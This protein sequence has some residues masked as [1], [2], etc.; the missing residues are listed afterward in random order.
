MMARVPRLV[1]SH[2]WAH[3][4]A[5]EMD[6]R[7][8]E[9]LVPHSCSL[10]HPLGMALQVQRWNL[11]LTGV[12]LAAASQ[13]GDGTALCPSGS[14]VSTLGLA[15]VCHWV[16]HVCSELPGLCVSSQNHQPGFSVPGY[17]ETHL[18]TRLSAQLF[19][20]WLLHPKTPATLPMHAQGA[21]P[22][23]RRPRVRPCPSRR[24]AARPCRCSSAA[25]GRTL[26]P[27]VRPLFVSFS[28]RV[29]LYPVP[30]APPRPRPPAQPPPEPAT[31]TSELFCVFQQL[32]RIKQQL[33][34]GRAW[35]L[36]TLIFCVA[37]QGEWGY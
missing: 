8:R 37:G 26:H 35:I 25:P 5:L 16:S 9:Q 7:E 27:H 12:A 11:H 34:P 17:V 23:C 30:P 18:P 19:P 32:K 20:A 6:G 3:R 2:I 22:P 14:C 33:S 10:G 13:S 31:H 21:M 15:L 29:G 4:T 24:S 28:L 1:L 36:V